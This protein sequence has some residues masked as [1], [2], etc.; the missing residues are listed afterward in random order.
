MRRTFSKAAVAA[1]AVAFTALPAQAANIIINNVD[2]PG[3]GFN[4][5]TPVAPVG[6]NTGATLGEQRL[7]VFETAAS[8]WGG[9]L[10]SDVTIV[11][12][13]T[14]QPLAC[15]PTGGVLGSA[16]P[17]QIFR[18][19]PA[20]APA[21]IIPDT[22]YHTALF[23]AISGEDASPG[24]PDPGLL[25]P[26]F[27][28]DIVTFFNG[29][30]GTDPNCLTGLN[31][32]NG[33]DNN[34]GPNDLDLLAVVMHELAHGLG[35][36]EFASEADGSLIQGFPGIYSRF[37]LDTG[38][39]Q[40]F[41]DMSNAQRLD[42]QV[43]GE[44][45]VWVGGRV[46]RNARKNLGP[47]PMVEILEP[48]SLRES[49]SAQGASFGRPLRR[50]VGPVADLV[51]ADDGVG[52]G[53]DACEPITNR[54]RRAIVLIDRGG[55]AFTTKVLNAQNAR[56]RGVIIA[57]NQPVG[58]AP[59]GGFDD[60]VRIPSVG[61]TRD[62]GDALKEALEEFENYILIHLFGDIE[63]LAGADENGFV[64]LFAPNP[65]QPG[66]SKSH[67]DVSATPN[68]LMEPSINGDLEPTR[69]FDLTDDLF[70]DIGWRFER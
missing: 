3:I 12:Q 37:M 54:V 69:T 46:T 39:G 26:P 31:W 2:A 65:V 30:I 21:G 9:R 42:A 35:F 58:P 67:F 70:R 55:C 6:G 24:D 28:D 44:D 14:F 10:A 45:L 56:A 25:Q 47:L 66:S 15:S 49:F 59:M 27:A 62:Q 1:F 29:A 41:A 23:N 16:G 40:I 36:S 64:R 17:L 51:L 33:L 38:Q 68:L 20:D 50:N 4:D 18:A 52:V 43:A 32:Y 5:M 61:I 22:W 57:N 19:D 8:I 11:V 34:E 7:I 63:L 53:T 48:P 13:A 60:A